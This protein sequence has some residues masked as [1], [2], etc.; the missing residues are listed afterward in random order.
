M[1]CHFEYTATTAYNAEVGAQDNVFKTA[2]KWSCTMYSRIK[3]WL[4]LSGKSVERSYLSLIHRQG[5]SSESKY[6][7]ISA[8]TF[9]EVTK[10][11]NPMLMIKFHADGN[12]SFLQEFKISFEIHFKTFSQKKITKNPNNHGNHSDCY[13]NWLIWD[14]CWS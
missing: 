4:K 5:H 3:T 1:T 14:I 10:M 12:F 11:Q 8:E 6:S 9:D 13:K 2:T 7:I